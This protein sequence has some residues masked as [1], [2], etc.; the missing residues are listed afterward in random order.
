MEAKRVLIVEDEA[1]IALQMK[2][3]IRKWGYEV[4]EIIA[5]GREAVE[6]AL[7]SKPDLILMDIF[8]ADDMD[9]IEVTQKIH[10]QLKVPII[11]VTASDDNLTYERAKKTEF[12]D[13]ITKPYPTDSL[14]K[15]ID[16]QLQ[17]T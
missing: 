9:G 7:E 8:L 11:Y 14:K 16:S 10:E 1:I 15:A 6:F 3:L 12:V 13:Y 17:L 2:H 4:L 5:N